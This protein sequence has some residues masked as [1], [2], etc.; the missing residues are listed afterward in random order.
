MTC[1]Y[2]YVD[3]DEKRSH[4]F[5]S[6]SGSGSLIYIIDEDEPVCVKFRNLL[7][8]KV[9]FDACDQASE[10]Q[11]NKELRDDPSQSV[12]AQ[13]LAV[14]GD[15]PVSP[16]PGNKY[17]KTELDT[18]LDVGSLCDESL[19]GDVQEWKPRSC[20]LFESTQPRRVKRTPVGSLARTESHS[21]EKEDG[22][23][24]CE[25]IQ[26]TVVGETE[27]D[28]NSSNKVHGQKLRSFTRAVKHSVR[29]PKKARISKVTKTL[30]KVKTEKMTTRSGKSLVQKVTSP[31]TELENEE[32]GS[33]QVK[34]KTR[35]LLVDKNIRCEYCEADFKNQQEFY[36][37][38]RAEESVHRC[39]IC[40]KVEP[41]EA[42]LIVH[43]QKHRR[44]KV[45]VASNSPS[46]SKSEAQS[47][48]DSGKI[49]VSYTRKNKKEKMKCNICGLVVSSMDS[50][51]IHTLLHTGE[52]AYRCCVCGENFS[53]LSSRQHHMDI[54]VSAQRFKCNPCG[55]RFT[56]RAELAKHQL[57]HE[58]KCAL[59]GEV[60]PNKTSRTCHFRVSHPNDILKCSVCSNMFA[61]VEDLDKHLAYHKKGK[62]EQC[63]VCGVV[64]SKL[65]DHMLMH[66][67]V[68]QEKL[69]V[70]DQ[71]PMRYLRKS[72]LDR[73]M[74]THT[75]EKPYACNRCPKSFRSNGMLRKH[76]LTHTQ[77]R[78]YQCEVC[79]KRCSLRSNLNIHMRVHNSDRHFPCALCSQAFNHKNSLHGHMKSKHAREMSMQMA[80]VGMVAN[81][82]P[83]SSDVV[84]EIDKTL[85]FDERHLQ[86]L[87]IQVGM[88]QD[89][90]ADMIKVENHQHF[91]N[92]HQQMIFTSDM[93]ENIATSLFIDS[94]RIAINKYELQAQTSHAHGY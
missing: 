9:L 82:A 20:D 58:I 59:C 63:P 25:L 86:N 68:A 50:L 11:E 38:R 92:I 73:H 72:N 78:P 47:L 69:Y 16:D 81:P 22:R 44:V 48:A 31:I 49:K 74:R 77:E 70:C 51:K 24:D 64:V 14:E 55:E 15:D 83:Q 23:R 13:S 67:Q 30:S 87:G 52:F 93:P 36:D 4:C 39:G 35:K 40:G 80:E 2:A 85:S 62:K 32:D 57:T 12:S 71:C 10:I 54:H 37:H 66:S 75:G 88:A 89:I 18:E 90:G 56:S 65:K 1:A 60:F 61:T 53:S 6:K 46:K 84:T 33:L 43:M 45:E 41:Y 8:V 42:H 94:D 26:E 19:K 27:N 34:E 21:D 79:G 76:L 5:E 3:M 17:M 29:I 7:K 91:G 28:A